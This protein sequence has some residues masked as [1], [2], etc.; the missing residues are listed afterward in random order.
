MHIRHSLGLVGAGSTSVQC[1]WERKQGER[2]QRERAL[3]RALTTKKHFSSFSDRE[4][5][6]SGL[7]TVFIWRRICVNL[8][9]VYQGL[10][11]V[12]SV[13]LDNKDLWQKHTFTTPLLPAMEACTYTY[14]QRNVRILGVV[15]IV[16]LSA[17][18]SVATSTTRA[19]DN[20]YFD[21]APVDERATEGDAALLRCDVSNRKHI[22]FY[23]ELDARPV[24]NTSR[25]FQDG[26]DL[27]F[28]RVD[29]NK[30][31]GSF[32]C[33]ATNVT[34]GVSLRSTEARLNI[35]CKYKFNYFKFRF[36][37]SDGKT[38]ATQSVWRL[39][40]TF[41]ETDTAL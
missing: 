15:V 11:W 13:Q 29:K 28:T 36:K 8:T 16:V 34:T 27:R 21:P 9:T 40:F 22:A 39:R 20:F 24:T 30:D 23:W 41:V 4:Q 19:Q 6:G 12:K 26:S 2:A 7:G 3:L 31:S 10:T 35:L 14:R 32:R 25:R 33:I 38:F 18:V 17:C 5:V 37:T 1:V